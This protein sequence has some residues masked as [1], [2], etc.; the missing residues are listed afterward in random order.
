MTALDTRPDVIG[1]LCTSTEPRP[2]C[3]TGLLFLWLR[4]D[5][6]R[7]GGLV[8][9]P[10]YRTIAWALL[11][12]L[13]TFFLFAA[14]SDLAADARIGLPSD[15]SGVFGSVVGRAWG[16]AKQS[17]PGM[18]RYITLLEVAYAVHELVFGILFLVIVAIPFRRGAR[19]AWWSCWAVM[20][21]NITYSLT[22]GRHDSAILARSL[23]A[24][25]AL[26]VLLLI[27]APVFFGRGMREARDA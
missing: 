1:I 5:V 15:H 16:A 26:P 20:L 27:Q 19:W 14:L 24:D 18:T 7:K 12:L 13:G 22:F 10:R 8:T 25:I 21:A 23:I 2:V 9:I 6:V 11:L 17:S 3:V 4:G